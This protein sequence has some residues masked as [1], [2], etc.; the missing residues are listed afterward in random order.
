MSAPGNDEPALAQWDKLFHF[1][2]KK[3]P[4]DPFNRREQSPSPSIPLPEGEGS[5]PLSL[6]ERGGGEGGNVTRVHDLLSVQ[7]SCCFDRELEFDQ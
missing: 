5:R 2:F 4:L 1:A 7:V 6:R 3:T